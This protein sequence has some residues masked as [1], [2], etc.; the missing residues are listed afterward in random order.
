MKK[1]TSALERMFTAIEN[2]P[3]S[4][5]LWV[6]TFFCLIAVRL[7]IDL[8]VIGMPTLTFFQFFFQ[9]AHLLLFFLFSYLLL[10]PLV[11]KIGKTSLEK[12]AKILLFGF[13]L[14][15]FAPLLDEL[16]FGDELY[17]SFYIFDGIASMPE[18][19][20]TFFGDSPHLGITYG[21]R[22]NVAL[23]LF[24][25]FLYGLVKTKDF[26]RTL[27]YTL[28]MYAAL[29]FLGTLPSWLAYVILSPQTPLLSITSTHIA[30][31]FLSPETI[32]NREVADLRSALGYKMG[33]ILSLGNF[34]AILILWY[35]LRKEE[36]LVLFRNARWPQILCQNG[37]LFLGML[38]AIIYTKVSFPTNLFSILALI[39]LILSVTAAWI[40][41]TFWNDIYDQK[42]DKKTNPERP[43]I[44]GIITPEE[45]RM[46]GSILFFISLLGAALVSFP[47]ALLLLGYQALAILYSVPP[48]R[49]KRFLGLATL[50][51]S[52][53][54]LLILFIGYS[55]LHPTHSLEDLPVS[56]ILYLGFVYILMLPLKDFKDVEG[57]KSDHVYT[58]PVILG[59]ERAKVT[60]SAVGF[61][62]FMSSIFVFHTP[63]LLLW[64]FL[65]AS[66]SFWL[67]QRAGTPKSWIRYQD[68]MG[69]FVAL[70]VLYG[71]GLIV[72]LF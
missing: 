45:Y 34:L 30:E 65:F 56:L 50:T 47:A 2:T 59:V 53:A 6:I 52:F 38:L 51:V 5:S 11:V 37:I 55:A 60:M 70:T 24:S 40:A 29:F 48:F 9:W 32:L 43:L 36:W 72:F 3:I 8:A 42:I 18:R 68:L 27:L 71:L 19:F 1:I 66:L 20:L 35:H 49:L 63:Q 46:Y 14:I 39:V 21:T 25:V 23:I 7:T 31:I 58:L 12:A 64:A 62:V 4:L 61:L 54:A 22:I 13:L 67:T 69:V 57:D 26:A 41:A 15:L 16:I 44:L 10:L 17:W 33:L 28:L